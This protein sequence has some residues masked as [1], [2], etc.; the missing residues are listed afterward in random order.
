MA[1][2]EIPQPGH[3][4]EPTPEFFAALDEAIRPGCQVV[5]LVLPCV[6]YEGCC[7]PMRATRT[8]M[9]A[10]SAVTEEIGWPTESLSWRWEHGPAGADDALWTITVTSP[11]DSGPD[12]Y[13]IVAMRLR[14]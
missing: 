1:T 11:L 7:A 10:I 6:N 9:S 12:Y 8:P 14:R 13:D 3:P 2:F 5:H 4:V